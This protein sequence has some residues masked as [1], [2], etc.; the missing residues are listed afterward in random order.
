MFG[1]LLREKTT[2]KVCT[3]PAELTVCPLLAML[4]PAGSS[5]PERCSQSGG[6]QEKLLLD[7]RG[8]A[9]DS[10]RDSGCYESSEN[11]ENGG[12]SLSRP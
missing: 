10:P 3:T 6:S 1:L 12:D 8:L 7:G 11:L 9:G 5:D 4:V 2:C